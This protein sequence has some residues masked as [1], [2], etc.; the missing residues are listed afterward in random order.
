MTREEI[1]DVEQLFYSRIHKELTH[2][3]AKVACRTLCSALR[4]VAASPKGAIQ[5]ALSKLQPEG[6]GIEQGAEASEARSDDEGEDR[7]RHG[8]SLLQ[9]DQGRLDATIPRT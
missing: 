2:Y 1:A 4:A 8:P 5:P 7:G 6:D 9:I 3:A